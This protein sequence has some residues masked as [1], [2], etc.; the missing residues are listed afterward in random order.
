MP[1]APQQV[2]GKPG[3]PSVSI[4]DMTTALATG[5]GAIVEFGGRPDEHAV[6]GAF[7]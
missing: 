4:E 1:Y 3:E 7:H 6:G 2:I 5:L